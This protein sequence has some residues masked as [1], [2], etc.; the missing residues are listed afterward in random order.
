MVIKRLVVESLEV[1]FDEDLIKKRDK[2][3]FIVFIV[4]FEFEVCF[5]DFFIKIL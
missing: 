4:K 3:V 2:V 5:F 1:G